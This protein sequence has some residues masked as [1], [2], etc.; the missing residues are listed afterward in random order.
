M[1]GFGGKKSASEL[2]HARHNREQR[3]RIYALLER[4]GDLNECYEAIRCRCPHSLYAMDNFIVIDGETVEYNHSTENKLSEIVCELEID[5]VAQE[6]A[7]AERKAALIVEREIY[8]DK[9]RELQSRIHAVGGK[10]KLKRKR[11]KIMLPRRHKIDSREWIVFY[12][13]YDYVQL[14]TKLVAVEQVHNERK[15]ALGISTN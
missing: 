1:L 15:T 6:K 7:F 12:N 4:Y 10:I 2:E 13:E 3:D 8:K 14:C 5:I 11:A 9:Y